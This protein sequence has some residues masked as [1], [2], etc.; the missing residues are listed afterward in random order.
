MDSP[1]RIDLD[2]FRGVVRDFLSKESSSSR[3][4]ALLDDPLGYDPGLWAKMA[5]L[6]WCGITVPER[7]GGAGGSFMDC[8]VVI[9]ELGRHLTSGPLTSTVALGV[10][11]LLLAGS[12]RQRQRWLPAIAAGELKVT[13]AL[14]G[15]G[16]GRAGGGVSA[17]PGRGGYRL[18]GEAGFV[19]DAHLA[20]LFVVAA[21]HPS[22]SRSLVLLEAAE[23]EVRL[24]PTVDQTRR[25]GAVRLDT[26]VPPESVLGPAGAAAPA[27]EGLMNRM[28]VALA[29]DSVGGVERLMEMTARY[30][31]DRV[32]FGRPIA[33]FQA[34]KHRCADMAIDV[35]ASRAA[36]DSA[37]RSFHDDPGG[38]AERASIASVYATDAY[39]RVAGAAL[40]LH[41]GIGYTWESDIHLYLKRAKLNQALFGDAR[42]HRRR[43]A[44][45]LLCAGPGTSPLRVPAH[46]DTSQM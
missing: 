10:G 45:R 7:Y 20:D 4:R 6:G 33:T 35:E 15:G 41:G 8:A 11:A 23:A 1:T 43:L 36:L 28:A 31:S 3:V 32:Q 26:E 42:W 17:R 27:I 29:C 39:A 14:A 30:V 12:E 44:T 13:A 38:D 19:P 46:A 16:Y 40:Q 24:T 37:L 25:L 22:G 5:S 18:I 34:V 21:G 2:D 9:Q